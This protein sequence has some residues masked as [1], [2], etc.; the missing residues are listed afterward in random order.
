MRLLTL[1]QSLKAEIDRVAN[2]TT[3]NSQKLL[4][5]SYTSTFQIGDKGGQT[6]SLDIASVATSALGMGQG[7]ASA[8]SVV[9]ARLDLD[10]SGTVKNAIAAGDIKI[11]GQN[12]GAFATTDD[13]E[14]IVANINENVDNVRAS[15]FNVVVAKN[16]GDGVTG[17][18]ATTG[19]TLKTRELGYCRH[20]VCDLCIL[21][22]A[23]AG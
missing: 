10:S 5:G 13:V 15:A 21:F 17:G 3:F 18:T 19:L 7:S 6:V 9:S 8:N 22:L 23:G 11:N 12:L 2:T 20:Y 16:I 4:D 14:A 1:V